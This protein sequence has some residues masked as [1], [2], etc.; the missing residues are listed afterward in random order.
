MEGRYHDLCYYPRISL[1][2]LRKSMKNLGQEA[3]VPA[4]S[5][6]KHL[7]NKCL[8]RYSCNNRLSIINTM[9]FQDPL[10]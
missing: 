3:G 9:I 8:E 7:L 2:G 1:M 4:K 5:Q 10:E 6:T